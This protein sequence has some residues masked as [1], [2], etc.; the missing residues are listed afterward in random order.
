MSTV[1]RKYRMT[2][3]GTGDYILP[4]N[5]GETFWRISKYSDGPSY[6]LYEWK[7]DRTFWGA[8]K[9]HSALAIQKA[10]DPLDWE[11]WDQWVGACAT[12]QEAINGALNWKPPE[13]VKPK[14]SLRDAIRTM[15]ET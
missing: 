14:G 1:E 7:R 3:I 11:N 15:I 5:D 6:G 2:R 12:R 4:A 8:W 13:P 10:D 9:W